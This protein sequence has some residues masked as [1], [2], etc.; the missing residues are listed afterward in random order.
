MEFQIGINNLYNQLTQQD[1]QDEQYK[2][3][4]QESLSSIPIKSKYD[5][6]VEFLEERGWRREQLTI[7]ELNTNIVTLQ[8]VDANTTGW[9]IDIKAPANQKISIQ[10]VNQVSGG[11][12]AQSAHSLRVRFADSA[13]NELAFNT[14]IR[15]TKEKSS[16]ATINLARIFYSDINHTKQAGAENATTT[17]YKIDNEW[18]RFKQGI[19]INGEQRLRIYIINTLGTIA[20]LN[21]PQDVLAPNISLALDCDLWHNDYYES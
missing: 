6:Y 11:A 4:K 2:Q 18:Y 13:E 8:S 10:G 1:N 21:S 16:G 3:N 17:E 9:A 14:K 12:D 19:E 15:I 5:S 7:D 20:Q